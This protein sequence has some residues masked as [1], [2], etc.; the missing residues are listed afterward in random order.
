MRKDAV[1]RLAVSVALDGEGATTTS[2]EEMSGA[3]MRSA[4]LKTGLQFHTEHVLT[5]RG[6]DLDP[7]SWTRGHRSSAVYHPSLTRQLR[8][9]REVFKMTVEER[10][11]T[12][13][14]Q[15]RGVDFCDDCLAPEIGI[16]RHQARNATS[17]LGTARVDFDRSARSNGS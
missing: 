12:F 3:T 7:G 17:G 10:V 1:G 8:I 4:L 2:A 5:P 16:N 15:N 13:L 11:A 14:R 9:N 6:K